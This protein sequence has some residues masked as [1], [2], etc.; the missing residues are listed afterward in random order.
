MPTIDI[1]TA[2]TQLSH[3]VDKAAAGQEVIIARN[4]QPVAKLVALP[5]PPARKPWCLAA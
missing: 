2:D 3:L 1:A 5:P 4:G